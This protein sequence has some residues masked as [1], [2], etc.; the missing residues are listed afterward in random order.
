MWSLSFF[1]ALIP[2]QHPT[3]TNHDLV[4]V[5]QNNMHF[6]VKKPCSPPLK[7]S[8]QLHSLP[9]YLCLVFQCL[10]LASHYGSNFRIGIILVLLP[11]HQPRQGG[12][13]EGWGKL[14]I[15]LNVY[16][17][18]GLSSKNC[19]ILHHVSSFGILKS[20]YQKPV[21]VK[22]TL[23]FQEKFY[24]APPRAPRLQLTMRSS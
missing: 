12:G 3:F 21:K 16:N 17:Y 1:L 15:K 14:W 5:L 11:I 8:A 6:T 10:P 7:L 24:G 20:W 9:H 22:T 13:M 18:N 19:L 23:S 4:S 2:I